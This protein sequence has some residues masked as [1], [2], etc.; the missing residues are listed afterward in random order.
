MCL[1]LVVGWLVGKPDEILTN[2]RSVNRFS[3]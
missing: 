3:R 2:D 1:W